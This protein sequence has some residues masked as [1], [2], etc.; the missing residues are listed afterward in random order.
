MENSS[1]KE[2]ISSFTGLKVIAILLL[3]WHHGPLTVPAGDMGARPV[4]LLIIISGFLTAYNYIDSGIGGSIGDA[5]RFMARHLVKFWPLH[6]CILLCYLVLSGVSGE[7][8]TG[9]G[10]A[11]AFLN[12]FLL[13]AWSPYTSTSFAFNG[14]SWFLSAILFCYFMAPFFLEFARKRKHCLLLFAILALARF[15]LEYACLKYKGEIFLINFHT[16]PLVR[17]MEFF[18]AVL[19]YP[20][21][22]KTKEALS[23]KTALC[24]LLELAAVAVACITFR[25]P[26]EAVYSRFSGIMTSCLIVFAFAFN[27]GYLSRFMSVKPFELLNRI[28]LEFFMVEETVMHLVKL[29]YNGN[30]YIQAALMLAATIAVSAAYHKL[31]APPLTKLFRKI[32][33]QT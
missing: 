14:S 11:R 28:Q 29:V 25:F 7:L 32:V 4:E 16:N 13:Q 18:M 21:F 23:G 12:L 15:L 31:L 5:Y 9:T 20:L 10:I 30:V 26:E 22:E 27:G 8:F 33:P 1:R 24:T 17:S 19:L 6:I 2:R 3:F